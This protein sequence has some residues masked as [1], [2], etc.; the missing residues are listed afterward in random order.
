[1]IFVK[2]LFNSIS[3]EDSNQFRNNAVSRY[4]RLNVQRAEG[5]ANKLSKDFLAKIKLNHE[6][7]MLELF[8]KR[9]LAV[10]SV[11]VQELI[12]KHF[13]CIN[14]FWGTIGTIKQHLESYN[15][16]AFTFQNDQRFTVVND[17]IQP[18][19]SLFL[20]QAMSAF[21]KKNIKK[22]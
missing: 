16:L 1:M 10:D 9:Q 7:L 6:K 3:S 13:Y 2:Y 19:F 5:F 21:I 15:D 18:D 22:H 12:E 11:Q 8:S 20:H 14:Q 4:G 17:E